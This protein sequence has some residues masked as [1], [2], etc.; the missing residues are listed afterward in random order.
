MISKSNRSTNNI[1]QFANSVKWQNWA[2]AGCSST[3]K[4][5]KTKSLNLPKFSPKAF[6]SLPRLTQT[7]VPD[8]NRAAQTRL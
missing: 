1:R 5:P 6:S 7:G 8:V 4:S 3:T 2:A